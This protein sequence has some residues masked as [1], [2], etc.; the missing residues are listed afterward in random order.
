M[1]GI[2]E[3][4]ATATS[5]D[6][7]GFARDLVGHDGVGMT[8]AER[9]DA[10]RDLEHLKSAACAAQARITAR[11]H[12][13]QVNAAPE[14]KDRDEVARS[15]TAQVALARQESPSRGQQHTGVALALVREMPNTL[16]ALSTGEINEWAA[17]LIVRETACLSAEHRGQVD[18]E[19]R[20][21]LTGAGT[22][23]IAGMARE[24]AYRLDPGAAVRRHR[25]AVTQ[26]RVT[27]RPAPDGMAYLT[28][29][30]PLAQGVA[31]YAALRKEA[32]RLRTQGDPRTI[33]QIMADLLVERTTGQ[34]A[35]PSHVEIQLV[36]SQGA[37]LN[38]AQDAANLPGF[39]HIP[40]DLARQIVLEADKTWIR[41]LFTEPLTG[42]LVAMDSQ[43][44]NFRGKLAAPARAA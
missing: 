32:V 1:L 18:R 25:S 6:V 38:G 17:T 7:A 31:V 43:R 21:R 22:R 9:I 12:A 4:T 34:A 20:G 11:F 29:L 3:R 15:A 30:L 37:L 5:V 16:D 44:R 13:S 36:M 35:G 27:V 42:E 41:R 26:R 39:G 23:K 28:N 2:S 33:A 14:L 10:I 40:A 19:L 24:I 8:D